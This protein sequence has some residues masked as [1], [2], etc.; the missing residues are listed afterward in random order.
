LCGEADGNAADSEPGDEPGDVDAEIVEDEDQR[1]RE[2]GDAHQQSDD[3]DRRSQTA[4]F[5][6]RAGA[7][8]DEAEDQLA[9]PDR[10]LE[11]E[12]DDEQEVDRPHQQYRRIGMFGDQLGRTKDDEEDAGARQRARK[13][14]PPMGD[15]PAAGHE[16]A[17]QMAQPEQDQ[18]YGGTDR[19][20]DQY[21]TEVAGDPARH[22][23]EQCQALPGN[24]IGDAARLFGHSIAHQAAA[25][26]SSCGASAACSRN[27]IRPRSALLKYWVRRG[28]R[29]APGGIAPYLTASISAGWT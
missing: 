17:A 14:G 10:R 7:M 3:S 4:M 16:L 13:D 1:D 11:S 20:S 12:S 22:F 26:V 9:C 8:L 28:Q 25:F 15:V 27:S 24:V 29:N 19:R 23:V 21:V 2:E 5:G 18:C 6:L